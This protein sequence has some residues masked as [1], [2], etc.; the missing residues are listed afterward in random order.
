MVYDGQV[1]PDET[2][3]LLTNF[4]LDLSNGTLLLTFNEAVN[5]TSVQLD[6]VYIQNAPFNATES[7]SLTNISSASQNGANVIEVSIGQEDFDRIRTNTDL[8][9]NSSNTYVNLT[10]AAISDI[11]GNTLVPVHS[12]VETSTV[13]SD[14][15]IPMLYGYNLDMINGQ[16]VLYFSEAIDASMVNISG[17][18]LHN[19]SSTLLYFALTNASDIVGQSGSNI[20]VQIGVE[21]LNPLR[22]AMTFGTN[23]NDSFITIAS[24]AFFDF[25]NNPLDPMLTPLQN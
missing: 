6:Q 20:T 14:T 1:V 13:N 2:S 16:I 22:I 15:S 21:D 3:P 17:I 7:V 9:T 12:A 23:N 4:I 10:T 24:D 8:A 11:A 19:S 5:A 25:G 18:R